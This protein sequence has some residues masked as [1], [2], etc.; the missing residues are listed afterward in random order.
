MEDKLEVGDSISWGF[1]NTVTIIAFNEWPEGT[2][3]LIKP[4]DPHILTRWVMLK[5]IHKV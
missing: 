3:V 2:A 5:E 1:D 4:D